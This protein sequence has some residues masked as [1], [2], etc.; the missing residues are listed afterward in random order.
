MDASSAL[1]RL[2]DIAMLAHWHCRHHQQPSSLPQY[3]TIA[4]TRLLHLAQQQ[5]ATLGGATHSYVYNEGSARVRAWMVH[6]RTPRS[7]WQPCKLPKA[8]L[9]QGPLAGHGCSCQQHSHERLAHDT[10]GVQPRIHQEGANKPPK[11]RG[12]RYFAMPEHTVRTTP[13]CSRL[14]AHALARAP[15]ASSPRIFT[16]ACHNLRTV[17]SNLQRFA[18]ARARRRSDRLVVLLSLQARSTKHPQAHAGSSLHH[19]PLLQPPPRLRPPSRARSR[20]V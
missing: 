9:L 16:A 1:W 10:S 3:A 18:I 19:H 15:C 2:I 14:Q 17:C 11:P 5:T 4:R 20:C 8:R 7:A 6:R 13:R 12:A